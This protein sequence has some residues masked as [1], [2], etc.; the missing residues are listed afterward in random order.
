M[1]SRLPRRPLR[2]SLYIVSG[3]AEIAPNASL[4]GVA[5][6]ADGDITVGP[7]AVM[8]DVVLISGGNVD[9]G[10]GATLGPSTVCDDGAVSV[11]IF[12]KDDVDLGSLV[13]AGALR[14]FDN[15]RG[16]RVDLSALVDVAGDL[17]LD[18]GALDL[19]GLE[20]EV[21]ARV[22][23]IAGN[24][25]VG[26]AAQSQNALTQRRA[27]RCVWLRAVKQRRDSPHNIASIAAHRV[28]TGCDQPRFEPQLDARA[29]LY[30]GASPCILR[31]FSC[32]R[33]SCHRKV[34]ERARR[35]RFNIKTALERSS[36]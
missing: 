4:S 34:E 36:R 27:L 10:I 9:L 13:S 22:G 12:A 29:S 14:L 5:I 2:D 35:V 7:G 17:N 1:A 16:A 25:R 6:V 11:Y 28:A 24:S 19:G 20:R 3:P 32:C 8:Q 18:I 23:L 31:R 21:A 15:G 30:L 33:L 26:Y